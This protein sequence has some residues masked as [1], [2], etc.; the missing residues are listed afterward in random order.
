MV[1]MVAQ[2]VVNGKE[3]GEKEKEK[4]D[5]EKKRKKEDGKKEKDVKKKQEKGEKEEKEKARLDYGDDG[6]AGF[7]CMDLERVAVFPYF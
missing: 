3:K 4:G 5:K 7:L 2:A 6:V 1:R